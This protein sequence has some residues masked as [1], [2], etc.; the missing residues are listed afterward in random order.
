MISTD[1]YESYK[2]YACILHPSHKKRTN[3]KQ[4]YQISNRKVSTPQLIIPNMS[5]TSSNGGGG[6]GGGPNWLGLLKWSLGQSDGTSG[7]TV[8]PMSTED[9]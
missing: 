7:T 9:K 8:K 2:Y 1:I 5:G 4:K 3:F 6:V